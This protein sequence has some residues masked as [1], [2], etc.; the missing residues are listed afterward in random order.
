M[1]TPM[2]IY[3]LLPKTN[4]K[5]CGESTCMAFAVKLL[6]KGGKIEECTP[7]ITEDKYKGNLDKLNELLEPIAGATDTGLL[8][9][10]DLCFG[11]GNCV[12]AC[13]VNVAN[14]PYGVGYGKGP[15]NDKMILKVV[16]KTVVPANID[17]CR[18]LGEGK[19]MC[20]ACI[21]VCPSEAIE[22]V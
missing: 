5:V 13:P 14:D 22:F 10:D 11:C 20:V 9:H 19:I 3:Q 4:C 15:T 21:D 18:R 1:P 17:N 12:V 2:E 16:N 6:S 7:V 8:I